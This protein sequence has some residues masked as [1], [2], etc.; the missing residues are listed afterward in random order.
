[1]DGRVWVVWCETDGVVT[2][3][4]TREA[5]AAVSAMQQREGAHSGPL[6]LS[7]VAW[8]ASQRCEL[9]AYR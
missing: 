6:A 4:R 7:A 3:A 8:T 1:M 9:G 5:R 2:T